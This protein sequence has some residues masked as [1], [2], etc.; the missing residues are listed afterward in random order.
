[1]PD[2]SLPTEYGGGDDGKVGRLRLQGIVRGR[3]TFP[4]DTLDRRDRLRAKAAKN[5]PEA[6]FEEVV[7]S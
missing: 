1:M 2:W 7:A 6:A 4:P 3:L 5:G